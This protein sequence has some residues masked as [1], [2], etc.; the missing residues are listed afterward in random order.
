MESRCFARTFRSDRAARGEVAA[1]RS[2]DDNQRRAARADGRGDQAR[3]P[4]S[5]H[6]QPRHAAARSFPRADPLRRARSRARRHRRR[7]RRSFPASRSTRSSSAASTTTSS[8]TLVEF[9]KTHGA[10]VRFIEYMDV[11]GAT[12]WSW[13]QCHARRDAGARSPRTTAAIDAGRRTPSAAGRAIPAAGRHDVRDHLV[14]DRTVLRRVRSQP[15]HGRRRLVFVSLRARGI[16]LRGPLRA[17]ATTELLSLLES[18]WSNRR[19]RGAE[20]RLATHNRSAMIP[21]AR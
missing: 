1:R 17:G 15:P 2:R 4:A 16:D 6:R 8:S 12:R 19:D 14:N 18:T 5:P 20:A 10:E 7:R 11:G 9:A 13:D 3:G 21:S